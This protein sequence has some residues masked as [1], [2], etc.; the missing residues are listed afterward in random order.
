MAKLQDQ[1]QEKYSVAK[2]AAELQAQRKETMQNMA[3]RA[4]QSQSPQV[5][6][7]ATPSKNVT[8]SGSGKLSEQ[9]GDQLKAPQEERPTTSKATLQDV[10]DIGQ[11]LKNQGVTTNEVLSPE[12]KAKI[13][14]SFDN[15]A[16]NSSTMKATERAK[17]EAKE[18]AQ[19][20]QNT[21]SQSHATGWER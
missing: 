7:E 8:P 3:F 5:S 12:S 2:D 9:V 18:T 15:S 4:S 21:K 13:E 10:K 14:N 11:S 6:P 20:N 16:Q 19:N 17:M 1:L